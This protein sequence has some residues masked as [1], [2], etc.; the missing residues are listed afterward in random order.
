SGVRVAG[1]VDLVGSGEI[2]LGE[3]CQLAFRVLVSEGGASA[4]GPP[5][6]LELK[7]VR[8]VDQGRRLLSGQR[9]Q[10]APQLWVRFD[11]PRPVLEATR[12]LLPMMLNGA[13]TVRVIELIPGDLVEA[14]TLRLEV[15][16]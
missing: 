8:G 1:T 15:L 13:R 14:G 6:G 11:G 2:T 4:D 12:S 3:R 10:I 9:L 7:V 16:E 5:E